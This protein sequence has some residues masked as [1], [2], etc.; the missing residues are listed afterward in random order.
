MTFEYVFFKI[1]IMRKITLM[2]ALI[3]V[4]FSGCKKDDSPVPTELPGSLNEL[5]AQESFNWST[6]M[7]VVLSIT[8]LPTQVP[9]KSTLSVSLPDGSVLFSSLHQMDKDLSLNLIVPTTV[10]NLVLKYGNQTYNVSITNG[11]ATFSFIPV[12]TEE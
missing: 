1:S 4:F 10:V 8:G 3:V 2:L 11:K 6:G 7:P 12:I 9:V 5:K